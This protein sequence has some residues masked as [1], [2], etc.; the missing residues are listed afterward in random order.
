MLVITSSVPEFPGLQF[1][2]LVLN[3][4][5]E[6]S[7]TEAK[8]PTLIEARRQR[9]RQARYERYLAVVEL[10]RQGDTDLAIPVRRQL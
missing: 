6:Y 3:P 9:C 1:A 2:L 10:Q 5:F 7:A 4:R 8:K